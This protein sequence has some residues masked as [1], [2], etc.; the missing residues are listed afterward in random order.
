MKGTACIPQLRR[1]KVSQIRCTPP[2]GRDVSGLLVARVVCALAAL[3]LSE[4]RD[5][6]SE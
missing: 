1:M 2:A 4:A 5:R 6:R 3:L